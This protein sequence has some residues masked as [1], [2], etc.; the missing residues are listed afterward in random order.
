MS[1]GLAMTIVSGNAVSAAIYHPIARCLRPWET[2]KHYTA[3]SIGSAVV[4]CVALLF[5]V[6]GFTDAFEEWPF[7]DC[8]Y[9]TFV[10]LSSIG[11]GTFWRVKNHQLILILILPLIA[12]LLTF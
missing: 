12:L 8:F 10:T 9:Y 5:A 7:G 4:I 2:G 6:A 1:P 11:L 3:V